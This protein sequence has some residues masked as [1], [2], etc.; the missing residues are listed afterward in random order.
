MAFYD[1]S[2]INLF[3]LVSSVE[4]EDVDEEDCEEVLEEDPLEDEE[5]LVEPDP[6]LKAGV[7]LFSPSFR[8]TCPLDNVIDSSSSLFLLQSST[9]TLSSISTHSSNVT[10]TH[11]SS[12]TKYGT[13]FSISLH[14]RRTSGVHSS[15]GT[16]LRTVTQSTSGTLLHTS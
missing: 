4:D 7:L 12:G 6:L 1:L 2:T 9:G 10:S 15:S 16:L 14:S 3:G 11:S 8:T 5:L 13:F